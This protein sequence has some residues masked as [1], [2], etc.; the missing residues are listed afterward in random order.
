MTAIRTIRSY[1]AYARF[2]AELAAINPDSECPDIPAVVRW[3]PRIAEIPSPYSYSPTWPV[4]RYRDG[5]EVVAHETGHRRYQV[6]D[7][8]DV[9][10]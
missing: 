5:R 7:V 4:Y 3:I 9:T 10:V 1:A 2:W 8:T 6:F